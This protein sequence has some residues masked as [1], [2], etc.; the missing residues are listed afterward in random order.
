MDPCFATLWPIPF[1][2]QGLRV[3]RKIATHVAGVRSK[4]ETCWPEW[5]S[6]WRSKVNR[7]SKRKQKALL[8]ILKPSLVSCNK[9]HLIH[10]IK[11]ELFPSDL[12]FVDLDAA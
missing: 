8:A 6:S 1:L 4:S 5:T 3:V 2:G 11:K 7:I 12:I 9:I 10:K